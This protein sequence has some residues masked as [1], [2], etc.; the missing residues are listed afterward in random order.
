MKLT[1]LRE[2]QTIEEGKLSH[3]V[4]GVLLGAG[5]VHGVA[6]SASDVANKVKLPAW[7]KEAQA[8]AVGK[9]GKSYHIVPVGNN[10]PN[11]KPL[12][13]EPLK[14]GGKETQH[15]IYR[16]PK[17]LLGVTVHGLAKEVSKTGNK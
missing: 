6:P 12:R 7:S 10:A 2:L 14:I 11:T 16:D 15:D 1:E 8:V 5:V 4:A 3:A 9:D 13:R 17:T